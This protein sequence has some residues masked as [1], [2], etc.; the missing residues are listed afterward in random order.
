MLTKSGESRAESRE[1]DDDRLSALIKILDLGLARLEEW[2]PDS[3]EMIQSGQVMGTCDYIA[4]D[5]AIDVFIDAVR[6]AKA[7]HPNVDNRMR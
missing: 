2:D 4:P 1:P 5:A 3:G 6:A 7:N